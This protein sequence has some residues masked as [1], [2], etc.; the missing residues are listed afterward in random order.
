MELEYYTVSGSYGWNQEKFTDP[1]M[2]G[3][4][5]AAVTACDSLIYF[6]K[7]MGLT[8]CCPI[9]TS[10]ITIKSY[11]A[12][13]RVMKPY[14]HPR[15][16]GIDSLD[17]YIDGL[18]DYLRDIGENRIS[19]RGFS[20][21][22]SLEEAKKI[23][24]SQIDKKIPL[25]CLNLKH[26]DSKFKDFEWH[27][28]MLTGYWEYG[29]DGENAGG[30]ATDADMHSAGGERAGSVRRRTQYS[31]Q[32]VGHL[33]VKVVSY[34]EFVW[35]DFDELWQTGYERKG[36]LIIFDVENDRPQA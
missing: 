16:Q 34:G 6:S 36:G 30:E 2:K 27:W 13:S 21:N 3:G 31:E 35:L 33:M 23:V 11:K 7:Y 8:E 15:W 12:F 25:P 4:G 5:C 17:I 18:T 24:K 20:G 22:G 10:E 19:I 29:D 9:E 28:F 32:G 1:M 26:K 14:L